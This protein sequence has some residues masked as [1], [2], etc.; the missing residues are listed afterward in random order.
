MPPPLST[1]QSGETGLGSP[2]LVEETVSSLLSIA[3]VCL[4]HCS[5]DLAIVCI[6]DMCRCQVLNFILTASNS[7]VT[8]QSQLAYVAALTN[9]RQHA[10]SFAT[11]IKNY[12]SLLQIT[13]RV[14]KV[15]LILPE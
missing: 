13:S 14:V 3:E 8:E 12:K 11:C 6:G 15:R 10:L 5:A 1:L 9:F 4:P 2:S 7:S